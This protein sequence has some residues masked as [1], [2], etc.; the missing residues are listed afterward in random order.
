MDLWCAYVGSLTSQFFQLPDVDPTV[1]ER[2]IVHH[3]VD[4]F[5]DDD[6]A[7]LSP[8]SGSSTMSFSSSFHKANMFLELNNVFNNVGGA[9]E[10]PHWATLQ[11]QL[12]LNKIARVK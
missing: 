11:E 5:I 2:P 7:Q 9:I 1:V 10:H 4:D 12:R 3:V 6:D 8:Q